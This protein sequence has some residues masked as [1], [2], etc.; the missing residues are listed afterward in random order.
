MNDDTYGL[1]PDP[2]NVM[3]V[4]RDPG[5]TILPWR[6]DD[7]IVFADEMGRI[8]AE[9]V[10]GDIGAQLL[11]GSERL[12]I[13]FQ[14]AFRREVVEKFENSQAMHRAQ[15]DLLLYGNAGVKIEVK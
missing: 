12:T 5:K 4:P 7:R 3:Q 10:D 9:K 8:L 1:G 6:K 14:E 11:D 15:T 2:F 13:D